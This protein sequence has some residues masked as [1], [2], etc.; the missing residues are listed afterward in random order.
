[1]A[2]QITDWRAI[3][4]KKIVTILAPMALLTSAAV[5]PAMAADKGVVAPTYPSWADVS[6]AG[7]FTNTSNNFGTES[8]SGIWGEGR[9]GA[10]IAY[11]LPVQLDV[12]GNS[13]S[14]CTDCWST[15]FDVAGHLGLW[16][17]PSGQLG[18]MVSTG[19]NDHYDTDARFVT[20]AGEGAWGLS[21]L[22]GTRLVAQAGWT[23][24]SEGTTGTYV[25]GELQ[26]ALSQVVLLSADLGFANTNDNESYTR[27]GAQAD[28]ML[29][30][31]FSAFLRWDGEQKSE[32]SY[33]RTDN[34]VLFGA[35]LHVNEANVWASSP[36][37]D[38]NL[39]TGVNSD[40]RSN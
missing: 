21:A 16:S 15:T 36:F 33:H 39:F 34:R 13:V 28:V 9:A 27:Y 10:A 3:V 17:M 31:T 5:V 35:T 29:N 18:L 1:V 6:V 25:Q 26:A 8:S 40:F 37:H 14:D 24:G 2:G 20:I 11:G 30:P 7:G 38:W 12:S 22:G 32:G 19:S 4:I 23:N